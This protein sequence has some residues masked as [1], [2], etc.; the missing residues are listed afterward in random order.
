MNIDFSQ[1]QGFDVNLSGQGFSTELSNLPVYDEY[2]GEYIVT[3]SSEMQ[4]LAT[5]DRKLTSNVVVNP[6]PDNCGL[7]TWDGST[8]TVS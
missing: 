5:T 3:P 7:I 8:L 1:S 6:I 2:E 4:I